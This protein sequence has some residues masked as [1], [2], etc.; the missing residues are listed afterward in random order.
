MSSFPHIQA[1]ET[2][3]IQPEQEGRVAELPLSDEHFANP[4]EQYI[5]DLDFAEAFGALE[6][7]E[8]RHE[9]LQSLS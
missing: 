5:R 6:A 1:V 9:R 8:P 4:Y 2:L 3:K 7:P